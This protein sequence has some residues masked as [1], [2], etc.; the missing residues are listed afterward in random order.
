MSGAFRIATLGTLLFW[1][2]S[3]AAP[4][5]TT[6]TA[7]VRVSPYGVNRVNGVTG[8][9]RFPIQGSCLGPSL[10]VQRQDAWQCKSGNR[11]YDPCFSNSTGTQ[12]TCVINVFTN[13]VVVLNLPHS[14]PLH[15]S[16]VGREAPWALELSN[17]SRCVYTIGSTATIAGRRLTYSC[18]PRGFVL[19]LPATDTHV[20]TAAFV[21][22][23]NRHDVLPV[24]VVKAYL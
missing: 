15:G 22:D 24:G 21:N 2:A 9:S 16:E 18:T 23:R 20:W 8:T 10:G 17:G 13:S 11:L 6:T 5:A 1:V 4:A 14:L 12:V 19:G 7:V 3:V